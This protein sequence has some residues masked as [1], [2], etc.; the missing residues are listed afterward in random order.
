MAFCTGEI[1]SEIG[2]KEDKE[3]ESNLQEVVQVIANTILIVS[4]ILCTG[5]VTKASSSWLIN[6]NKVRRLPKEK[7]N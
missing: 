1:S 4:S 5:A 3:R 2:E 7:K 6:V